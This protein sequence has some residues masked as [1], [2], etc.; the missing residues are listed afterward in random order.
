[1]TEQTSLFW[2]INKTKSMKQCPCWRANSPS[3]GEVLS[4]IVWIPKFHYR[5]H[6]SQPLVRIL[7]QINL[8]HVLPSLF[9]KY[10]P[11]SAVS[12]YSVYVQLPSVSG[13]RLLHLSYQLPS[14]TVANLPGFS[15]LTLWTVCCWGFFDRKL[16]HFLHLLLAHS[17][18]NFAGNKLISRSD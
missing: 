5:V 18:R 16:L 7:R 8:V 9:L 4:R 12:D 17:L 13:G 11:L 6:A 14:S 15:R 3:S 2:L 1:M 10:H